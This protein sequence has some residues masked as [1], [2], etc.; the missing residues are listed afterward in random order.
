[1]PR[2]GDAPADPS[3]L[4]ACGVALFT[5]A[6]MAIVVV[7]SGALLDLMGLE[8]PEDGMCEEIELRREPMCLAEG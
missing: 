3:F 1:M 2:P 7:G 8:L 5:A 4:A 6:L